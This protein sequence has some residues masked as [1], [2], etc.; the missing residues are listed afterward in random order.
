MRNWTAEE[1]AKEEQRREACV[2]QGMC[3]DSGE[4]LIFNHPLSDCP[5][6][7]LSCGICDCFGYPPERPAR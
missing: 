3:P 2:N 5:P 6:N 1:I 7:R 4:K